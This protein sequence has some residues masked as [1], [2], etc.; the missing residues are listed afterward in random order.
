VIFV[1]VQ[2]A[3][4]AL[5]RLDPDGAPVQLRSGDAGRRYTGAGGWSFTPGQGT[6][7]IAAPGREAATCEDRGT[8]LLPERTRDQ[9][10]EQ[11]R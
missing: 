1:E 9:I 10:G 2:S 3:E 6:A 5:A 4:V 7:Q 11:A 8:T